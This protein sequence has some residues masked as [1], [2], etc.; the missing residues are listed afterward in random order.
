LSMDDCALAPPAKLP[1][2]DFPR[3]KVAGSRRKSRYTNSR[4]ALT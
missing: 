4:I 3:L 2:A 1:A